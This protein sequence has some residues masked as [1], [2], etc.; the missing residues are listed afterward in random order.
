MG[1]TSMESI[2]LVVRVRYEPI[3]LFSC[4]L[5]N[6]SGI[7]DVSFT[8]KKRKQMIDIIEHVKDSDTY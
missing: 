3:F 7:D 4:R 2:R 8:T 5:T 6:T 1:H